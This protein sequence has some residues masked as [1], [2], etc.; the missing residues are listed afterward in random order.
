MS[1]K[2]TLDD[3][4]A[5]PLDDPKVFK[6][7]ADDDL[8]GIFQF[9][10]RATRQ[11]VKDIYTGSDKIPDI[12]D[13]SDINALSR[14]GSL[15]SGMTAKYIKVARGEAEPEEIWPEVDNVLSQ[16]KGCLVYQ[17]QVM[18]IGK[19]FGGMSDTEVG[20]L[21]KIIGAKEAGGAFE[22]FWLKFRDGAMAK[23]APEAKAREVW[24]YMA[25]SATYLF[26]VAHSISYATVAYWTM[27]FKT[28]H[29][30]EFY[31]ASLRSAAKKGKQKGKV[32]PQ[33]P[34]LQ[35][36]VAHGLTVSPPHPNISELTWK[37]NEDRTGVIAGFTQLPKVGP[38][39]A[40]NMAEYRTHNS[41]SSWD[42]MAGT[43]K[44]FGNTTANNAK[45]F[46]RK[47]DPFGIDLT[48]NAI[49]TVRKNLES[50]EFGL[51]PPDA[52]SG[53]IPDQEGREVVYVGHVIAVKVIDVIGELR[54][55][56]GLTTEEAIAS[57]KNP[58]RST[59]AK[60]ICSDSG[61]T[62]VHI[63]ISRH[64]YPMLKEEIDVIDS[65]KTFVAHVVGQANNGFGPSVQGTK[66][67]AIEIEE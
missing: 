1:N 8:T 22:E 47:A 57:L 36:V 16:T 29:P 31:A 14:P 23:G 55:R 10:G 6:G 18:Q 2:I 3:L 38:R 32:E 15:T 21:R 5:L 7:F 17:E 58:D 4:Y 42:D 66:F 46:C 34:I 49:Y 12:M 50:G 43:V 51:L 56:E 19:N 54:Q 65:K 48:N 27:Y 9:E 39:V 20:R 13:L 28:Y 53:T 44:G 26:N 41:A 25:A 33:L 52:T 35:D 62:E 37:P 11:I 64:K 30:A 40:D 67:T 61:G 24:E 45:E 63:N 60:I 59:K